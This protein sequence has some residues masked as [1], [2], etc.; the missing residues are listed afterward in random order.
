MQKQIKALTR[1]QLE[2]IVTQVVDALYLDVNDEVYDP[3]NHWDGDTI[4]KVS[5]A[6]NDAG[7]RPDCRLGLDGRPVDGG[8][9]AALE[10]DDMEGGGDDRELLFCTPACRRTYL[11]ADHEGDHESYSAALIAPRAGETCCQ[12]NKGLVGLA[13]TRFKEGK[14]PTC[15]GPLLTTDAER[16]FNGVDICDAICEAC[17]AD[18]DAPFPS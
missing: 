12:C 10:D 1:Q 6:I 4:E 7:L 18:Q 11:Q 3:D 8:R 2:E 13:E 17:V 15:G 14:C 9:L 5:Q 16:R